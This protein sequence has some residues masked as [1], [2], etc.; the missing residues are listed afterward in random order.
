MIIDYVTK[1]LGHISLLD[2]P[3]INQSTNEKYI[4]STLAAHT[5]NELTN[6]ILRF[7]LAIGLF[8]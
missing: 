3:H 2:T 4:E 1:R 6:I 8:F 7:A 5:L